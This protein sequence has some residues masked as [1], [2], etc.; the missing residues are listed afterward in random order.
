MY[1]FQNLPGMWSIVGASLVAGAVLVSSAK[2]IVDGLPEDHVMKTTYLRCF[3]TKD[4]QVSV[5]SEI[6]TGEEICLKR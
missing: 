1:L 3:Y 5:G 4:S 6:G 2:K